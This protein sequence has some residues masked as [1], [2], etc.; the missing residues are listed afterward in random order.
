MVLRQGVTPL[1]GGVL[2]GVAISLALTRVLRSQLFEVSPLDPLTFVAV[3][4]LF[5]GIAL[6]ACHLPARRAT[7]IDPMVALRHE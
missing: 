2:S 4:A 1:L 5:T 6:L 7:R 3:P